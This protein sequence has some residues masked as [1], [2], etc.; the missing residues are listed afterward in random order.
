MIDLV[1]KISEKDWKFMRDTYKETGLSFVPEAIKNE[2]VKAIYN[3]TPYECK[4][5]TWV[6]THPIQDDDC[7]AYMCSC[8]GVGSWDV[9]PTTWKACP[10]CTALMEA[11]NES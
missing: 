5:G 7:G 3:S 2:C 8:C 10:W 11:D 1:I 4:T 6:F 9:N